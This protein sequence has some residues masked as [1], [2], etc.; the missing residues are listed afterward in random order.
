MVLIK[1][2]KFR[3]QRVL[4]LVFKYAQLYGDDNDGGDAETV[5]TITMVAQDYCD[6]II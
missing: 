2:T 3:S 5:I 6:N 4:Q 1:H